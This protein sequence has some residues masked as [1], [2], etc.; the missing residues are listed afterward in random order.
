[1]QSRQAPIDLPTMDLLLDATRAAEERHFWFRGFRR[2]LRPFAEAATSGRQRPLILDCGCGTGGNLE[3]LS[4]FGVPFGIELT[5]SGLRHARHRAQTRTARATVAA[6][7]FAS[8]QFDLATSFDVLYCLDEATERAAIAE[9]ARIVRPG[10]HV[11]INV[12]AMPILRGSHSILSQELRRYRRA[13]LAAKLER[14]GLHVVRSTYTN[15]ALFPLVLGVRLTQRALGLGSAEESTREI[16]VP[17]AP[18]NSLLSWVL[19]LEARALGFIDMPFGSSL[20]CLARKP[21]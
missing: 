18:I 14:A 8:N 6:L 9:M 1:M 13:D 5:G 12:A 4:E 7:P 10:G 19:A 17:P 21:A 11:I 16:A 20:L 2:F 3:V 15:A